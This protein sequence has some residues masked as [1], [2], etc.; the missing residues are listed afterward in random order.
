MARITFQYAVRRLHL[1]L[2]MFSLPWVLMYGITAIA[3]SHRDWFKG[4][5][6][7]WTIEGEWEC[8]VE[9][10]AEGDVS[11]STG[12]EILKIAGLDTTAFGV[13]RPNKDTVNINL[14][15]FWTAR[16]LVYK[17]DEQKLTLRNRSKLTGHILTGMHVRAGFHNGGSLNNLWGIIVDVVCAGFTLW[18]VTGILIWWRIKRMRS[19]GLLALGGGFIS[20]AAFIILL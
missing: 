5:M 20:F 16:G 13:Y 14:S 7:P 11:R 10:P 19:W 1:Y 9:V 8:S 18:I 12:A 2:G 15:S 17:V 3:F 6:D 4:E